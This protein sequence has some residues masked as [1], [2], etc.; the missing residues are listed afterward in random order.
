MAQYGHLDITGG[1]RAVPP[2]FDPLDMTPINKRKYD[3]DTATMRA[4]ID[5]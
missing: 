5:F 2:L 1:P 4:Q 3:V